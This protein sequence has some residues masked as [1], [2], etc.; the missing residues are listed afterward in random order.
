MLIRFRSAGMLLAS[1]C[2]VGCVTVVN[3]PATAGLALT[4]LPA[5]TGGPPPT[6]SSAASNS[7]APAVTGSPSG[8]ELATLA[9]VVPAH[10]V[11]T[12]TW[13]HVV[14]G[15]W[16]FPPVGGTEPSGG[17]L[18]SAIDPTQGGRVTTHRVVDPG[19]GVARDRLGDVTG[20]HAKKGGPGYLDIVVDYAS[21]EGPEIRYP[22]GSL[23]LDLELRSDIP[24]NAMD[25][26]YGWYVDVNGDGLFEW[27]IQ[28][29]IQADGSQ[30][31]SMWTG[32]D[33]DKHLI[34][35]E[36][37]V[38][39]NLIAGDVF[40]FVPFEAIGRSLRISV[41]AF[42]VD[43]SGPGYHATADQAPDAG[44]MPVAG[45]E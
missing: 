3:P 34:G 31:V 43:F 37:P 9:A 19:Q 28:V 10:R 21:L 25:L 14:D 8:T 18:A 38:T 35:A 41:Q 24:A 16:R 20:P 44:W 15:T 12:W 4:T 33:K 22:S 42:A 32:N 23:Q 7:P 26:S 27:V 17:R 36:A 11:G 2:L 29:A 6:S 40:A 1:I 45:S 5:T 39:F 13:W 30:L